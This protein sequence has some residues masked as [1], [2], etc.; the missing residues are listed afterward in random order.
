M[1]KSAENAIFE[2]N[3]SAQRI[4]FDP[5]RDHVHTGYGAGGAQFP[6]SES[7][8]VRYDK[9]GAIVETV[10][11]A[12]PE[13]KPLNPQRLRPALEDKIALVDSDAYIVG[14]WDPAAN[15]FET[16]FSTG[17]SLE[18][19]RMKDASGKVRSIRGV[20]LFLFILGIMGI[21]AGAGIVAKEYLAAQP[22]KNIL[23]STSEQKTGNGPPNLL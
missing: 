9:D 3:F 6:S 2:K 5:V 23:N 18:L 19:Q 21:L 4:L 14:L 10:E 16:L 15:M 8:I 1:L 20:G 11:L 12:G 7:F 17:V 22:E 13:G